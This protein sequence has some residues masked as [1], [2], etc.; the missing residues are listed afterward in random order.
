MNDL[1][2][3][4]LKFSKKILTSCDIPTSNNN[5]VFCS[6]CVCGEVPFY[7]FEHTYSCPLELVY[8]DV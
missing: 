5:I 1:D 4:V 2:I 3:V 7:S 8:T 6:A